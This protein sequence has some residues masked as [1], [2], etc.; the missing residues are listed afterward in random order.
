MSERDVVKL[1]NITKRFSNVVAN[2][3][4]N[5][6]LRRG[7][8]HALLG[9]NGAGKTTLMNILSGLYRPDAGRIVVWGEDVALRSPREALAHGIGMV[10]QH[11]EL[12]D[13]LTVAENIVL[14]H[15]PSG[16]LLPPKA[17]ADLVLR[18]SKAYGL[19]VDP[20]AYVWQLSVGERQRVEILRW[21]YRGAQLMILDEPTA[22]LTPGEASELYRS[23][24]EM[25]NA[26]KAVVFISHKLDEV[27]AAADRITVLRSGR[28]VGTVAKRDTSITELTRMMIGRELCRSESKKV[29]AAG[30]AVLALHGIHALSDRGTPA[31]R[32]VDLTLHEGEILGIAGVA[33]NGQRELAE[34]ITG[35]RAIT[36]GRLYVGGIDL[37]GA[38]PL[39]IMNAGVRYV[40]EERLG[41]GLV[42][43]CNLIDNAILR[44]FRRPPFKRG[45]WIDRKSALKRA[46][47]IIEQFGIKT[48]GPGVCA[49]DLSGGNLQKLLVGR[50]LFSCP[51]V[52]VVAQ[53]TRGL[54]IAATDAVRKQLLTLRDQGTGVL[55]I[56]EDLDEILEMSDRI[57]VMFS[58][59]ILGVV[60]GKDA[61]R[62]H[63]GALMGGREEGMGQT[64]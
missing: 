53:P 5:L 38:G 30:K 45:F 52:L 17:I 58:G 43:Q 16:F 57:A 20:H 28:V 25:A 61:T 59:R 19:V 60:S 3:G 1:V 32:G 4:I 2:E 10:H 40:P 33:G 64:A 24:R 39:R 56:S 48:P 31:L 21:L 37:T 50:E 63:V 15:R 23:L 22:V 27:M 18:S 11:F 29:S 51:K 44:D 9:E 41:T 42:P 8:I 12:V 36:S 46:E 34:V 35:L 55:L 54:D 26:G 14:G 13:T 47:L 6:T 49:R 62:E 7:E